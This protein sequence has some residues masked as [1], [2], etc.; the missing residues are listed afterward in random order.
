MAKTTLAV[1]LLFAITII[2]GCG[3]ASPNMTPKTAAPQSIT[4][5]QVFD[6]SMIGQT[7]TLQNGF[8]DITTI[9]IEVPPAGNYLPANSVI[10]H[11]RKSSCNA[12]PAV[13]VCGAEYLFALSPEPDGSWR[14]LLTAFIFPDA[15]PA[16]ANGSHLWTSDFQQVNGMPAPYTI[17]P[18]NT[19]ASKI[20]TSYDR[21][22]DPGTDTFDSIISGPAVERV[23]WETDSYEENVSTP[24]YTGPALVSEQFES[25]CIHEKWYFAPGFGLV[26]VIPFD[27]GSC[28]PSDPQLTMQRVN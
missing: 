9:T 26:K 4:A 16:W 18:A 6:A 25:T 5:A 24:L 14:S 15:P 13:G 20:P 10:F 12:Y 11:Y 21:W 3:G 27:N 8:G 17:V 19:D 22:D 7:W 23:R 2:S 1:S 28:T